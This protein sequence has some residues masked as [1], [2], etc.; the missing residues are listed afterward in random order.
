MKQHDKE[1]M[2]DRSTSWKSK[3]TFLRK[4]KRDKKQAES[5]IAR[6]KIEEEEGQ[7]KIRNLESQM[8][9]LLRNIQ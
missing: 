3:Q 5:A 6:L 4:R 9:C 8:F 2:R 1:I 7:K